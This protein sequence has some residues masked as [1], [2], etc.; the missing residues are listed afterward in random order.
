MQTTLRVPIIISIIPKYAV[1]D[2]MFTKD[3]ILTL[4]SSI[5]IHNMSRFEYFRLQSY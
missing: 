5:I 3:T 4:L 1:M 2:I